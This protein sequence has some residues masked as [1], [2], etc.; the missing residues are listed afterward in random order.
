MSLR[1]LALITALAF[2]LAP[3]AA[4]ADQ[5]IDFTATVGGTISYAGGAN[6]LLGQSIPIASVF[7][8]SNG[9]TLVIT[10]G[11]LNF[12]TGPFDP[13][14][15]P[16]HWDFS[17]GPNS[18]ITITGCISGVTQPGPC[19]PTDSSILLSGT[20]NDGI[21]NH[22]AQAQNDPARKL[23]GMEGSFTDVKNAALLAFYGAPNGIYSG[24]MNEGF[25]GSTASP[26]AAFT[27]T[28]NG[29]DT[30]NNVPVPEPNSLALLGSGLLGIAG[31]VR[32]KL[33]S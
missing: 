3:A 24:G 28:G 18:F 15:D 9:I 32:R 21:L 13:A 27:A 31:V 5:I 33:F 17:G 12:Q 14:S 22:E 25:F 16:D 11:F 26:H 8:S 30:V 6:P 23:G 7:G 10:N 19:G 2:M 4:F 20:W 1:K 29:G